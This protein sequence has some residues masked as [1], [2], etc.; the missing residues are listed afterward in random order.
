MWLASMQVNGFNS[1][2]F[3]SPTSHPHQLLFTEYPQYQ[4]HILRDWRRSKDYS[5][6][7]LAYWSLHSCFLSTDGQN[8]TFSE[9]SAS[10]LPWK[11]PCFLGMQ[12]VTLQILESAQHLP[13]AFKCPLNTSHYLHSSLVHTHAC[14]CMHTGAHRCTGYLFAANCLWFG[15][16]TL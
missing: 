13:V 9:L 4:R 11:L 6:L 8:F 3:M 7:H 15:R 2:N 14:R 12:W 5:H 10:L 16:I 1:I